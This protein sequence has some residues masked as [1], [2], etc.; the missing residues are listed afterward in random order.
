MASPTPAAHH[1]LSIDIS[2][3]QQKQSSEQE[4]H[5]KNQSSKWVLNSPDPPGFGQHMFDMIKKNVCPQRNNT[6]TPSSASL[7]PKKQ[8]LSSHVISLLTFVFPILD[9]G[10]NYKASKF[11][12]DLIAGLTLA[13][14]S[15]PQAH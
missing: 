10:R 3:L 6:C 11:K 4:F 14:L 13:S 7:S 8:P 9:W 1:A 12:N 5:L 2:D 15:I